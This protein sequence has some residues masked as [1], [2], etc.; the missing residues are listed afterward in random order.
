S[1]MML[2]SY[3]AG[4]K[5]LNTL[6]C[7]K[8]MQF[9]LENGLSDET[10]AIVS[11]F[12]IIDLRE[13]DYASGFALAARANEYADAAHNK[14]AC[15]QAYLF[16]GTTIWLYFRPFQEAINLL[17]KGF[18]YGME[19]GDLSAAVGSFSNITINRFAKGDALTDIAAHIDQLI[20][21]MQQHKLLVSAGRHY[22]RLIQMLTQPDSPDLL[23]DE[24]FSPLEWQIVSNST[25]IAFI[26]HLRL[27]WLFWN[28]QIEAALEQAD[29]AEEVIDLIIGFAPNIDHPL[30]KALI[31]SRRCAAD[32]AHQ[33][34]R[35]LEKLQQ[36]K[37]LLQKMTH[38]QANF[39]H[40]H[41][42]LDAEMA[43]L[44]GQTETAI[45]HFRAA[46]ASAKK[47]GFLQY[48]AL[49]N[50]M[51][52]RFLWDR[53][54]QEF[55]EVALKQAHFVYGRWGCAVKQRRLEREFPEVCAAIQLVPGTR[56]SS[57]ISNS[58]GFGLRG[59]SQLDMESILKSNL[60]ISSEL[61]RER[62]LS[63]ILHII[64]ENAGAQS[65]SLIQEQNGVLQLAA[66][67]G[68]TEADYEAAD[69][70]NKRFAVECTNCFP[71]D[72][73][74]YV[75]ATRK[76]LLIQDVAA[77]ETW[78]R[79]AYVQCHRP[80][81]ILCMPIHYRD[82]LFGILYLENTLTPNAFTD[83]RIQVLEL[84]LTQ[85]SIALENARLF[86]EVHSLNSD[87]EAKVEQRTAELR[88]VNK[89]LEAFSY[90]VSHDL[91]GP[92]RNINGF[93][94]MLLEQY[95]GVLGE[96]GRDLIH[97]VRRN[98]EKMAN[99]ISGLLELSKVTR[100][101]LHSSEV[102]LTATATTIC[103]EL[104][105]QNPNQVVTWRCIPTPSVIG[106]TRL[107]Y[108]ALENLLNNAWKYSSKTPHAQIEFGAMQQDSGRTVYYVR[109]NGAGFDMRHSQKLFTSFQRLHSEKEFSGT[110]VGLATVQRIIHRHG[111]DI[112]AEAEPNRGACFY[113]TINLN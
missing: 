10:A 85:A 15:L 94:K 30:I 83:Q 78:S 27:Q 25:L 67:V 75:L 17:W 13:Q 2:A 109:D 95:S 48:E 59:N 31:V 112:W 26:Q 79:D 18:Q 97:R 32:D 11:H 86:A 23:R 74:H 28:D 20:Q 64:L 16:S 93:S 12:V 36:Q 14:G 98:T 37:Q 51:L 103:E 42:L 106:D 72:M 105:A 6:L 52:G 49:A 99:L 90:S 69:C 66:R 4:K 57:I 96:E 82:T 5:A 104:Q 19:N 8:G 68:T 56:I 33:I 45:Q 102:D 84:L 46:I 92:L 50:E 62:L 63:K 111:G 89:E 58:S 21:L 77:S 61:V 47:F 100:C 101:E 22:Q 73:I 71:L 55:A 39:E 53:G 24:T 29:K 65:A 108:S 60:A 43:R 7:Y 76:S 38:C 80:Q 107:L 81:S 88:A 41:L 87:L 9:A 54:W 91:R 34:E 113:F 44:Q 1:S 35:T 110:G 40:K 3:V 70:A